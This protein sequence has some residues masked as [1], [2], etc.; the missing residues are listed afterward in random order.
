MTPVITGLRA[1]GTRRIAID[2]DGELW[3]VLPADAAMKS[4][5]AVGVA[6]DRECA[7]R[8]RV[9]LRRCEALEVA[10]R[11][12]RH[13]DHSRRSLEERLA[14][15]RVGSEVRAETLSTLARVG[16]LDDGRAA[17]ARAQALADRDAGD[18]LIRA[19]LE[20]RG[21]LPRD[22]DAAI[23]A[24]PPERERAERLIAR[25]GAA[26]RSYR[27]L[28]ARGFAEDVLDGLIADAGADALG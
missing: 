20:Q 3:R 15:S 6:L 4:G 18:L 7:R 12:L 24:L 19:D 23:E 26:P 14:H 11:S 27:R 5:L 16:L 2:L 8:V 28:A 1:V 9:E 17:L 13:R 22:V 10:F 21:F 25:L